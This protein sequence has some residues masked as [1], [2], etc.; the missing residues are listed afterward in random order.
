MT[1]NNQILPDLFSFSLDFSPYDSIYYISSRDLKFSSKVRRT[2]KKKVLPW[3]KSFG[4][5]MVTVSSSLLFKVINHDGV[6]IQIIL[7]QGDQLQ[8]FFNRVLTK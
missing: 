7:S 3:G 6:K 1:N 8:L 2:Q 5:D 4:S